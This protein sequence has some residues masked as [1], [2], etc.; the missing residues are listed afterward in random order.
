MTYLEAA[1]KILEEVGR[2]LTCHQIIAI[3][4]EREWID[5]QGGDP[6][7]MLN[8]L[9]LQ[10]LKLKGVRSE[11]SRVTTGTY[12]LRKLIYGSAAPIEPQPPVQPP[13]SQPRSRRP[14]PDQDSVKPVH[15]PVRSAPPQ[16]PLPPRPQAPAQPAPKPLPPREEPVRK[17]PQAFAAIAQELWRLMESLGAATGFRVIPITLSD[18]QTRCMGWHKGNYGGGN[19]ELAFILWAPEGTQMD[20]GIQELLDLNFHKVIIMVTDGRMAEAEACIANLKRRGATGLIS[21]DRLL[22][23]SR[24]GLRFLEFFDGL[25]D[26]RPPRQPRH[27][28]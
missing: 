14:R 1:A 24:A 25:R 17:A 27:Q 9:I 28:K 13:P 26:C 10:D 19:P 8:T 5:V 16:R 21:T 18:G 23:Q 20:A 2:P 6:A 12:S 3:A 22:E 15:Q 11:Y 7:G 4:T